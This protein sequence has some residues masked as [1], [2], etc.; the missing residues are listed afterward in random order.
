MSKAPS[1]HNEVGDQPPFMALIEETVSSA[2]HG[3]NLDSPPSLEA[4]NA[5]PGQVPVAGR[6]N[7]LSNLMES[8]AEHSFSPLTGFDP[9]Q[10]AISIP[11]NDIAFY[12]RIT[13]T[14]DRFAGATFKQQELVSI[15]RRIDQDIYIEHDLV[16]GNHAEISYAADCFKISPVAGNQIY[17]NGHLIRKA[18]ILCREDEM[19]L[20][21]PGGPRFVVEMLKPD[22]VPGKAPSQL[23]L[24]LRPFSPLVTTF[25]TKHNLPPLLVL[26]I[27]LCIAIPLLLGIT[28]I[29]LLWSDGKLTSPDVVPIVEKWTPIESENDVSDSET[30]KETPSKTEGPQVSDPDQK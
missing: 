9:E 8:S 13:P 29:C 7:S 22:R 15:G 30:S 19:T 10:I 24:L 12:I 20:V 11:A 23:P 1:K 28:I 25:A 17:I 27:E 2:D 4:N 3:L 21:G 18:T 5:D 16:G 26:F 6:H 14:E